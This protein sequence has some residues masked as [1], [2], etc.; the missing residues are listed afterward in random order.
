MTN[1]RYALHHESEV[2]LHADAPRIFALLDDHRRLA[3]HME[4]P[5]L[6]MAGA[7]M[8][9]ETDARQG[10]AVGSLICISG[11]VLGA[12]PAGAVTNAIGRYSCKAEG[13]GEASS[14]SGRAYSGA[15][16]GGLMPA[17]ATKSRTIA[18]AGS[19]SGIAA[20]CVIA[21]GSVVRRGSGASSVIS[22]A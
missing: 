5:S 20:D 18:S 16:L 10:Q 13:A 1:G 22:F 12:T 8:R 15:T 21:G 14:C 17:S 4:K 19:G 11:R 3:S 9:I 6:M 7:T 2:V